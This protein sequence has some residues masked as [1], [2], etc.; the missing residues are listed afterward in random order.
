MQTIKIIQIFKHESDLM[1]VAD[2]GKIY[3]WDYI[4][5]GDFKRYGWKLSNKYSS[6][7]IG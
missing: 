6:V 2:D 5:V 4:H 3:Y 7:V 1:A